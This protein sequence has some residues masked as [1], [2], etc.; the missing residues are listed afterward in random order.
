[1]RNYLFALLIASTCATAGTDS[2]ASLQPEK[3]ALAFNKWYMQQIN[4]E[5]YPITDGY[6]IDKYVTSDTMKK[7][8]KAQDPKYADEMYYDADFFIKAQDWDDDWVTDVTVISSDYDPVCLNVWVAFG[9]QQKHI[10]VDC[11]VK[12]GDSWMIQSVTGP[13]VSRNITLK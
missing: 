9:K 3:A 12:E 7:L 11:M 1:M 13:L 2:A 6:Q 8:R 4:S 5:K 10:V